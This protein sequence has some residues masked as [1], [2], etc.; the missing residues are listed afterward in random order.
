MKTGYMQEFTEHKDIAT[1]RGER[2]RGRG[3]EKARNRDRQTPPDLGT[4]WD[5][6]VM[7]SILQM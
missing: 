4:Y 2:E 1:E 3:R 6:M 5:T 7:V